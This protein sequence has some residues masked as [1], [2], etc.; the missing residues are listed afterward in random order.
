MAFATFAGNN[1]RMK[2]TI[3]TITTFLAV[4]FSLYTFA[5]K[6]EYYSYYGDK[7]KKEYADFYRIVTE[8]TNVAGETRYC[9]E[10][11]YMTDTL[12]AREY[13]K[14]KKLAVRDGASTSYFEKN[15]RKKIEAFYV[16]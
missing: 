13:Y 7:T 14:D 5:Q 9:A 10:D 3:Q 15:V 2:Q 4:A 12:R 8:M 16:D 1:Q 11:R 6:R